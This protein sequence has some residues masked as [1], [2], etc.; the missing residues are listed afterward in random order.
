M[1]LVHMYTSA[2]EIRCGTLSATI[3]SSRVGRARVYIAREFMDD[4]AVSRRVPKPRDA[5]NEAPPVL[6]IHLEMAVKLC[7]RSTDSSPFLCT[8]QVRAQNR[9]LE[10][11]LEKNMKTIRDSKTSKHMTSI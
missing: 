11:R 5:R 2:R 4:Q 7:L 8:G 1:K 6:D 10:L 3:P 9:C